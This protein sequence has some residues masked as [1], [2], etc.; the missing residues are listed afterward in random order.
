MELH[1]A[2]NIILLDVVKQHVRF[3][4]C[5]FFVIAIVLFDFTFNTLGILTTPILLEDEP[6]DD[7]NETNDNAKMKIERNF[8]QCVLSK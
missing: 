2:E 5:K 1:V 8:I 4:I 6:L 7:E 3:I